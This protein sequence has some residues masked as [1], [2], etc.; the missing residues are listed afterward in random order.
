MNIFL[1]IDFLASKKSKWA[2]FLHTA[3]FNHV[4]YEFD[5]SEAIRIKFAFR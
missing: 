2:D 4:E 5:K 3:V 1:K